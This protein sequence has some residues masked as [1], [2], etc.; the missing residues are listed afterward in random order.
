MIKKL[1]GTYVV[2]T[3]FFD[4]L[5]IKHEKKIKLYFSFYFVLWL[6]EGKKKHTS[7]DTN[8]QKCRLLS[9]GE[10]NSYAERWL[11]YFFFSMFVD[12]RYATFSFYKYIAYY[13]LIQS[14]HGAVFSNTKH[15][16][17][18]PECWYLQTEDLGPSLYIFRPSSRTRGMGIIGFI[19]VMDL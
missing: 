15:K 9:T 17:N 18:K 3:K 2:N 7:S 14:K 13:D 19:T 11:Y 16:A 10:M 6:K 8:S 4:L 12:C 5:L 1:F